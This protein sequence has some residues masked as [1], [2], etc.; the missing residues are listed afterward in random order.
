MS[1]LYGPIDREAQIVEMRRQR[2]IARLE[3]NRLIAQAREENG[4]R[5][6]LDDLSGF[7]RILSAANRFVHAHFS[8]TP[9]TLGKGA[10]A[11]G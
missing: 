8:R 6:L 7:A 5:A 11:A 4:S 9:G 2:M 1:R 3:T 10:S